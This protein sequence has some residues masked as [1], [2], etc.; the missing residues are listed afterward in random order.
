MQ[1]EVDGGFAATNAPWDLVRSIVEAAEDAIFVKDLQGRFIYMN[2]LGAARVGKTVDEILGRD[3]TVLFDAETAARL[4]QA[5]H[6]ILAQGVP[7]RFEESVLLAGEL[8]T[9]RVVK[10]PLYGPS[11][12]L[13]GLFGIATDVS[14]YKRL[15]RDLRAT[16]DLLQHIAEITGK[17]FWA[18]REPGGTPEYISPSAAKVWGVEEDRIVEDSRSLLN[19]VVEED[20]PALLATVARQRNSTEPTECEFRLRAPDGSI[21]W[22]WMRSHCIED[23]DGVPRRV[24]GVT[25]DI[26]HRKA[27]EERQRVSTNMEA[28]GRLAGGVAHDFNNL[29]TIIS[30]YADL[31]PV[32]GGAAANAAEEIRRAARRAADLTAQL[33]AVS[34]RQIIEPRPLN[35]NP[36]V[37]DMI[38]MLRRLMGEDI[39]VEAHLDPDLPWCLLDR[40]QA[41]T[42]LLN[43]AANARDAMPTG[44]RLTIRTEARGGVVLMVTDTG[45]GIPEDVRP[46]V[47]EPFFTTRG[48]AGT[49]LGLA[50]V[51]GA[52][53]QAQGRI[54]VDS[55]LGQGTT[56][57]VSFDASSARPLTDAV[58]P[59]MPRSGRGSILVVEADAA[60]RALGAL[61]LANAGYTVRDVP[62]STAALEAFSSGQRFDLLVTD[63]IMQGMSGCQF[64]EEAR[65]FQ[66]S[67][68]AL[69]VSGCVD[70][71][72]TRVDG[73]DPILQKPFT[74]ESLT[75]A[76]RQAM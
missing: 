52:V 44:G 25:E 73:G 63:L 75:S 53:M 35:L 17:V 18:R 13:L 65:R 11:G 68:K 43:L 29:L 3:Y 22:L 61:I 15:E 59:P 7:E 10:G 14:C 46:R 74:V 70:E 12:A 45:H 34:R 27:F 48:R 21:R 71:A 30:G 72:W 26:T 55:T 56:F 57:T 64:I 60:V 41:E 40:S 8:K 66:P 6:R 20:L 76:V 50:I 16:Q 42:I 24:G 49:G 69:I 5:D 19:H 67:L 1:S 37:R 38:N 54:S 51:H 39:L 31:L 58:P 4:E 23:V 9:F 2:P 47:F 33:L 62:G 28:L 36:V 32:T